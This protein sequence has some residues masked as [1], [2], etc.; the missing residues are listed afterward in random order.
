MPRGLGWIPKGKISD[1]TLRGTGVLPDAQGALWRKDLASAFGPWFPHWLNKQ[2]R[3]EELRG[4][5]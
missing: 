5:N 2:V 3:L 1:L 4:S